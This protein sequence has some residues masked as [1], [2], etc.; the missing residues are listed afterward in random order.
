MA[1]K[2]V[3]TLSYLLAVKR[4]IKKVARSVIPR[5]GGEISELAG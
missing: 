2:I 3:G 5:R 1:S 4:M